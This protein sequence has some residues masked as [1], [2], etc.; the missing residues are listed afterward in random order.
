[1]ALFRLPLDL[2]AGIQGSDNVSRLFFRARYVFFQT[3]ISRVL[4]GLLRVLGLF[5]LDRGA[6]KPE[7]LFSLS[8]KGSAQKSYGWPILSG[9]LKNQDLA[10]SVSE[11]LR[12]TGFTTRGAKGAK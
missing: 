5:D 7:A 2:R 6:R 9:F 12:R 3:R 11:K 8:L 4:R 10:Y 1:M